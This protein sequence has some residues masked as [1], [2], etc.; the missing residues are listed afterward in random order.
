M[1]V[2]NGLFGEGSGP[3]VLDDVHCRGDENSVVD[4]SYS[5]VHNCNHGEDA[6]AICILPNSKKI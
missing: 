1:A 4:C 2:S 6:G 5:S 3:I